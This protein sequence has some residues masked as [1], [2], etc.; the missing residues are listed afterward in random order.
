[1]TDMF[2]VIVHFL[3][4]IGVAIFVCWYLLGWMSEYRSDKMSLFDLSN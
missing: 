2:F 3:I 1:M 4:V